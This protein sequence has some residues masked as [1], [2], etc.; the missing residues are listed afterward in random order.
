MPISSRYHNLLHYRLSWNNHLM[1]PVTEAINYILTTMPL[2]KTNQATIILLV[3]L[4]ATFLTACLSTTTSPVT[5]IDKPSQGSYPDSATKNPLE[6]L[7]RHLRLTN[8]DLSINTKN[9][10]NE[11][12]RLQKV[13]VFLEN[14]LKIEPYAR[15]LSKSINSSMLS[16]KKLTELALRELECDINSFNSPNTYSNANYHHLAH[17]CKYI[18][19]NARE[20]LLHFFTAAQSGQNKMN[21]AFQALSQN[22]IGYLGNYFSE[23]ILMDKIMKKGGPT[24]ARKVN[25]KTPLRKEEQYVRELAFRIAGSIEETQLYEGSLIMASA[26]DRLL[27]NIGSIKK[28]DVEQKS[29]ST[30]G[31]RGD[32][33]F[34]QDTPLGKIIIGGRGATYYNS[35]RALLIVD[36]GGEDEYHNIT[37]TPTFD[38]F[39]T[40]STVIIDL[41]GNDL[42]T[43]DEGY[44]QGSGTFGFNCLIDQAGNDTYLS[45]DFSQGSGF[46]GVGILYDSKGNDRYRSD[47]MGQGAGAFGCGLLCDLEGNDSYYGNLYT[48]GFG[49]VGGVGLLLDV[50]G[51]DSY[52]V[53][54]TYS[55]YREPDVAFD[56][57]SQGCGLGDRYFASGGIGVLWD[58]KGN[59]SYK[60]NYFSQGSSYWF[61]LGLLLDDEGDDSYQARRYTQGSGTHFT[62]GALIDRSGNDIYASW[63]VSQGCGY[64]YSQG[65]L[66]DGEG[67]DTYSADW[68]SQGTSGIAGVGTLIDGSGNDSYNSG[69]FNSQGSGQY[70]EEK[71]ERSIGVLFDL[72]GKDSYT[73]KGKNDSLWRQGNYGGGIDLRNGMLEGFLPFWSPVTS[74]PKKAN[75]APGKK[76]PVLLKGTPLPELE[77]GFTDEQHRQQVILELSKRGP[78]IIPQLVDYL[79]LK[80]SQMTSTVIE[81]LRVMGPAATPPLREVL[82]ENTLDNTRTAALLT[83]LGGIEDKDSSVIF[84]SYLKSDDPQLRMLA[85]RGLCTLE[86]PGLLD[87]LLSCTKEESLSVR[88]Y[89]AHALKE[90]NDPAAIK[91]LISLLDDE[92]YSVRFSAFEALQKEKDR[93]KPYLIES[94]TK[95]SGP[96]YGSDLREDLLEE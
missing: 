57:F 40:F 28:I 22:D 71:A 81:V 43:A 77:S 66:F 61:A 53:G 51:D 83:A 49:F 73:G 5:T 13:G 44:A 30:E 31:L 64:D 33:L 37:A 23:M 19:E 4:I 3:L 26:V 67:N 86:Y 25:L 45:H 9:L 46:F 1:Q 38:P 7:L 42:Y 54:D 63:G 8:E 16:I 36:L 68:F 11:P 2:L 10:P 15:H 87:L 17:L 94:A 60:S 12:F 18:D 58:K 80:D 89:C 6:L 69:S 29:A 59:D 85:I 93:A 48:Q 56:S 90:V 47:I 70:N 52:F 55:D 50:S 96:L 82:E 84:L 91:A 32:I 92:H 74:S 76:S 20:E 24:P 21:E 14:P 27:K 72:K 79:A 35:I 65:L 41:E 62:V 78:S 39:T 75:T 34:C 88:K 95:N